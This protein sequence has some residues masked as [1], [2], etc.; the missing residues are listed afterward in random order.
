MK[1]PASITKPLISVIVV[2]KNDRG[3]A[4]TLKGIKECVFDRPY[5]VI[6]V[7]A[8]DH[9]ILADIKAQNVWVRWEQFPVS[10][11][12]TT[13]QQRNR[14]LE[15]ARGDIIAFIDANCEPSTEWLASIAKTIGSGED[16]VCG[17][18]N[19]LNDKNLVH[20]DNAQK[21][22][23]YVND[24]TTI[25]VGLRR[26]VFESVGNFDERFLFGQDVDFSW[27]TTDAGFKIYFNPDMAIAHDWGDRKEQIRRAYDYGYARA[28]LFRKHWELHGRQLLRNEPHVWMYPLFILGLPLTLFVP[29]Y[30]LLVLV[31]L[32][33]NHSSNPLGLLLHHLVFGWGVIAGLMS[34]L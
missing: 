15:L 10:N 8:S 28:R 18:V 26:S 4:Q 33:K 1:E 25:N 22:A 5:E 21:K 32:I 34:R 20:Y 24:C 3:I 12:R 27:R 2:V 30:P 6:V 11:K 16:I 29:F 19:D 14:G 9:D 31:P 17:P 7:D 23:G 13:P